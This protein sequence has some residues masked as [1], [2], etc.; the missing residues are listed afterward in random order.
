MRF[1][2]KT[3]GADRNVVDGIAG[4][5]IE[6]VKTVVVLHDA[7]P[8]MPVLEIVGADGLLRLKDM[9]AVHGGL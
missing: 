5:L 1:S 9:R 4:P 7:Q 2:P 8:T 3:R 6:Q